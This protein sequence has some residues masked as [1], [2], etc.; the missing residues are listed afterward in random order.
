MSRLASLLV[1]GAVTLT[2]GTALAHIRLNEPAPRFSPT[3]VDQKSPMCGA[4]T[5]TGDVT[6][7]QPG[8][9]I[10]V[11]WDETIDHPGHFRIS[12]DSDGGDDDLVDPTSYT[13][14]DVAPSV[15]LDN[16]PDNGG[17]TFSAMVTLPMV[18]CDKC[19]LQVI[20]VMTDKPPFTLPGND[21]YY[22]CADIRISTTPPMT[23]A[24]TGA[25]GSGSGGGATTGSTTGGGV[26]SGSGGAAGSGGNGA[27]GGGSSDGGESDGCGCTTAGN[28]GSP[29]GALTTVAFGVALAALRRRRRVSSR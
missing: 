9:T 6:W 5:P 12:L 21:I 17:S 29:L 20:Q 11:Q 23:T 3:G 16:I 2:S 13:D 26:T 10:T 24:T 15:L 4:G 8:E 22:W 28:A 14:F 7:Y 25:G 19:T 1:L 18:E 27:G